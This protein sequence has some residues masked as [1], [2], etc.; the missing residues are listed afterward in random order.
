MLLGHLPVFLTTWSIKL[1]LPRV[2]TM[3]GVPDTELVEFIKDGREPVTALMSDAKSI[4]ARCTP[5]HS[6]ADRTI[7]AAL[8]PDTTEK[9]DEDD[10]KET[11]PLWPSALTEGSSATAARASRAVRRDMGGT[12]GMVYASGRTR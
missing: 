11:Q 1:D 2:P 4:A 5:G 8:P 7:W 12:S 10:E 9:C 6:S 3:I